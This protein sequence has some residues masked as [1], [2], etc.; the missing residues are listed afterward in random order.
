MLIIC[1]DASL[2]VTLPP[3]NAATSAAQCTTAPRV[4]LSARNPFAA[5]APIALVTWFG[6]SSIAAAC[7]AADRGQSIKVCHFAP[8]LELS[9][10]ADEGAE[11]KGAALLLLLLLLLLLP[12]HLFRDSR[13]AALS[14]PVPVPVPCSHPITCLLPLCVLSLM[15]CDVLC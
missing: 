14:P 6:D 10:F 4:L 13:I 7:V 8:H 11:W 15:T 1:A 9:A 2:H 3:F 5:A 12:S